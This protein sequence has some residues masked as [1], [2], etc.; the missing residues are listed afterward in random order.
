MT[1]LNLKTSYGTETVDQLDKK[2]FDTLRSF[3]TELKKLL[4]DYHMANINVYV[5]QRPCK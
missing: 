5:S 1:Y 2:D 4:N 3:K